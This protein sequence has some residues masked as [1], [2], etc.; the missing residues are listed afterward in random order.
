MHER[1][2]SAR[3]EHRHAETEPLARQLYQAHREDEGADAPR[4]LGDLRAIANMISWSGRTEEGVRAGEQ[5]LAEYER[6]YGAGDYRTGPALRNLGYLLGHAARPADAERA[7]ERAAEV[8]RLAPDRDAANEIGEKPCDRFSDVA[9]ADGYRELGLYDK[10]E[11]FELAYRTAPDPFASPQWHVGDL[12]ML[13]KFYFEY[14]EYPKAL[15]YLRAC[16]KLWE[17][18]HPD[19][20]TET[21]PIYQAPGIKMM[22]GNGAHTFSSIAPSCL[23][24]FI[25]ATERVGRRQ[26]SQSLRELEKRNWQRADTGAAE[27]QLKSDIERELGRD[28]VSPLRVAYPYEALGFMYNK[29]ERYAQATD[30]FEHAHQYQQQNWALLSRPEQDHHVD[31]RLDSLL[32]RGDNAAASGDLPR[33]EAS[34]LAFAALAQSNLNNRHRWRLDGSARLAGLYAGAGRNDEALAMWKRY[35]AQAESSRGTDHLDYAWG[36]AGQA[37]V[38][39]AMGRAREADAAERRAQAIRAVRTPQIDAARDLPL[40]AA[41]QS[42]GALAKELAN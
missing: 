41:L 34:Y 27:R 32:M 26:Q 14:G 16:K 4:T 21:P 15:W 19:V 10:A 23:E 24:D 39:R 29:T 5:T 13:G 28:W 40:P 6:V 2:S 36:L 12:A 37:E 22:L 9:I 42:N 8:C 38:Y 17:R 3:D 20:S 35:L 11:I 33:A 25:D 31:D 7:F 18:A 1:L 30:A